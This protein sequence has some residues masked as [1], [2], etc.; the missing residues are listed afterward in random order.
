MSAENPRPRPFKVWSADR[1]IRKG[2]IASSL[3]D[4]VRKARVKLGLQEV[5]DVAVVL[6]VD[7]TE[8]DD[9]YFKRLEENTIILLLNPG[10]RWYPP[11]VEAIR[12]VPPVTRSGCDVTDSAS[13]S[14]NHDRIA[15]L[16]P[17]LRH[18]LGSIFLLSIEELEL[19]A[20]M[21][22]QHHCVTVNDPDFLIRIRD[23]CG[24]ILT[25]RQEAKEAL[26]LLQFWKNADTPLPHKKPRI[27]DEGDS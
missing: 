13:G 5:E 12:A 2:V 1:T 10:E 18:N 11:G 8:V 16:L 4:L 25:E 24:R 17:A 3:A 23:T 22:V 7:G 14:S 6:E 19:L 15:Q 26:D 20:D 27:L 9:E 21:D